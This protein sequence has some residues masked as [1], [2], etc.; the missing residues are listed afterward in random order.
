[1][2]GGGDEWTFSSVLHGQERVKMA[3]NEQDEK[4]GTQSDETSG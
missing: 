3:V 4:T 2:T 1:M